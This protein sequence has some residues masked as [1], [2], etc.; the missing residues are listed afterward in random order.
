[1]QHI[2]MDFKEFPKDKY[3]FDVIL[4]I[5][6]RLGKDSITI[7]CYK[8]I[9]ARG[10]ATLFINWV[11]RFGHT[12]ETIISDRGPQFISSF[13]Q[14]F[15]QIIG[16]KIKLSTAYHKETDGQTEIMNRYIDQRLRL[17]VTY[18]QDNWSELIPMMDRAQ[19][20]LPHSTIGMAP[21]QLKFGSV[22]RNSWD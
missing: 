17:F 5:I 20:T 10:L 15:C 7:P 4:V 16:V 21:Y 11:Y 12:P 6:D 2:C 19:M 18:Y 22:P 8:T 9:N 3:G 13:W 1:M 14:A